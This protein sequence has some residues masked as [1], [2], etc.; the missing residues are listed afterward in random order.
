MSND[1]P[2]VQSPQQT[3]ELNSIQEK[4]V[5]IDR[6]KIPPFM[7]GV[8][9]RKGDPVLADFQKTKLSVYCWYFIANHRKN[10]TLFEIISILM[11]KTDLISP[12]SKLHL[13]AVYGDKLKINKIVSK[14]LATVHN[15]KEGKEDEMTLDELKF[16]IG[17]VLDVHVQDEKD[18]RD[19]HRNSRNDS[20]R[21]RFQP[22]NRGRR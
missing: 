20:G 22:Y 9:V 12:S 19:T 18:H 11:E 7:V 6:T 1:L 21:G 4:Q 17:D 16:S 5:D 10:S 14:E 15:S 3:S 13:R 2:T 8:V